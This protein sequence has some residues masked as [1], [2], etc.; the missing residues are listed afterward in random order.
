MNQKAA[1]EAREAAIKAA[2]EAY[3][4][5]VKSAL[6]I[7]LAAAKAVFSLMPLTHLEN[8]EEVLSR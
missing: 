5:A 4:V 3:Q 1:V 6:D 2:L 8:K 7:Y